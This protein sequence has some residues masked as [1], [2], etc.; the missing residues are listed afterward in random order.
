MSLFYCKEMIDGTNI[1]WMVIFKNSEYTNLNNFEFD[2]RN[3]TINDHCVV[4]G[5][6]CSPTTQVNEVRFDLLTTDKYDQFSN[7]F[8]DVFS[9]CNN[10]ELYYII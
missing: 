10:H 7:W 8:M 4:R 5:T 6:V 9:T 2:V 1:G 3:V